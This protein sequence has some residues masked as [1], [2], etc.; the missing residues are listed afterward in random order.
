M[1]APHIHAI[2]LELLK[3]HLKGKNRAL[4]V[5]SGS[6]YF[7]TLMAKLMAEGFVYGVDHIPELVT[8]AKKNVGKNNSKL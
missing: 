3:D 5:G 2:S 8:L 1:E 7:T 4:D 6:G